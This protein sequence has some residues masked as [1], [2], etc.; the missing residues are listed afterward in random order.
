MSRRVLSNDK[1]IELLG[2]GENSDL[3]DFSDG[4]DNNEEDELDNLLAMNEV[5]ENFDFQNIEDDI[6]WNIDNIDDDIM[7]E[8]ENVSTIFI[9][10]KDLEI[11]FT[12][13]IG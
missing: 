5:Y 4:S 7:V 8:T 3:S 13:L 2:N 9:A 11:K 12:I 10:K 1:I 6:D